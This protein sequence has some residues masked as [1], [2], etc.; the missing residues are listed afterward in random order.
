M[1]NCFEIKKHPYVRKLELR[2]IKTIRK[3]ILHA[4]IAMRKLCARR[5]NAVCAPSACH[6]HAAATALKKRH[7][8]FKDVVGTS[9]GRCEDVVYTL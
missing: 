7:G 4:M 5:E 3:T 8:R 1:S 9:C 2:K 6:E